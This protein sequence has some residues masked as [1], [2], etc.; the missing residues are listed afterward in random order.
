MPG[1]ITEPNLRQRSKPFLRFQAWIH[2]GFHRF[3]E[4]GQI[5]IT[6]FIFSELLRYHY[7]IAI[8]TDKITLICG[9]WA[10]Q[11]IH[12]WHFSWPKSNTFWGQA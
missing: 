6:N 2:T 5:F 11:N 3:I 7:N 8:N 1:S 4:I 12:K 9:K 10:S